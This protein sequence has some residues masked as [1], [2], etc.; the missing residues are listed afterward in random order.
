MIKINLVIFLF[1]GCVAILV[2]GNLFFV[3][4]TVKEKKLF[5]VFI[6]YLK[7]EEDGK[8]ETQKET[9]DANISLE[10]IEKLRDKNTTEQTFNETIEG[11]LNGDSEY[12]NLPEYRKGQ[13]IEYLT[14]QSKALSFLKS[15]SSE[16][17][18]IKVM[19]K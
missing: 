8:D 6:E 10:L 5:N 3:D 2:D 1:I 17:V 14:N 13:I 19:S 12:K 7:N 18:E 15:E 11:K 4:L 9:D 16:K